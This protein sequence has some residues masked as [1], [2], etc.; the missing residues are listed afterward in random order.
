[1][2]LP[3][4]LT[5][6]RRPLLLSYAIA[7]FLRPG[8]ARAD[9]P[10][11]ASGEGTSLVLGSGIVGTT[12]S[13]GVELDLRARFSGGAQLGA[14]TSLSGHERAFM[15]GQVVRNAGS[16]GATGILLV[17]LVLRGPLE[18]DLR[19]EGG[20]L[21]LRGLGDTEAS[22][23]RQVN[24]LSML[25]HVELGSSF[26]LRAGAILGLELEVD[27][28][29]A[30]ADQSQLLTAGVGYALSEHVLLYAGV[31]GGGTYGFDGDN[32]KFIFEGT[33]GLRAPFGSGGSRVAY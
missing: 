18:F 31:T 11:R 2:Q 33:L 20:V 10:E 19:V 32:G 29:F 8:G 24:E 13:A 28:A 23:L 5:R 6:L 12:T 7:A 25:A 15:S 22:A 14:G 3:P 26:L 16:L 27:P 4:A 9:E 17:P 1:M 21:G 30:L